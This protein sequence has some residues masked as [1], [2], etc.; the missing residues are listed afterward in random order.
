MH[1][2]RLARGRTKLTAQTEPVYKQEYLQGNTNMSSPVHPV[3]SGKATAVFVLGIIS[4]AGILFWFAS[5]P[6]AIVAL[7][8]APSASREI[9][10]SHG[11]LGGTQKIDRGVL[12][13]WISLGIAIFMTTLVI[14]VPI[15]TAL[16]N[17]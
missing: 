9:A 7:S 5:I 15:V 8:L 6:C 1:G 10:M 12:M 16:A 14:T 13:A 17:Q 3:D 11:A 4:L 2:S